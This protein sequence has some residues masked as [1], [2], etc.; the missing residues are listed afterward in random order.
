MEKTPCAAEQDSLKGG[1]VKIPEKKTSM[2]S[3]LLKTKRR[4]MNKKNLLIMIL[5]VVV[6]LLI[7][8]EFL[9]GKHI[10]KKGYEIL[11]KELVYAIAA[12]DNKRVG[13]FVVY[14]L[15]DGRT[16]IKLNSVPFQVAG[17]GDQHSTKRK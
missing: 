15:A 13:I 6:P 2:R 4:I 5:A 11:E 12:E 10:L 9:L 3:I 1:A 17:A 7:Y 14:R 8:G 16:V